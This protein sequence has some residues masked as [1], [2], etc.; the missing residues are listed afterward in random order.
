MNKKTF[1]QAADALKALP[2]RKFKQ[3]FEFIINLRDLDLKKPEHQVEQWVQLPSGKGIPVKIGALVGPELAE[4]AK[5]ACDTV[6]VH[7]DFST[8]AND[9]KAIKKLAATHDYFIAQANLMAD[10][11]KTFGRYFG[12]RG[13][14]PN[15]KAGC[16]VPPNA[17]L[18]VLAE[19]LRKTVKAT[20]KMQPSVKVV[21]GTQDTPSDQVADNMLAVYSSVIPKLPGETANIR[22]VLLKLSMSPPVKILADSIVAPKAAATEPPAEKKPSKKKSDGGAQ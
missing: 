14:M 12:P 6:I 20:A 9:K 13:K 7:D 21:V 10:V 22:S 16:V 2:P 15:P 3:T 18:K 19:K 5:A 1:T 8:F 17:N 11:A 4:Q